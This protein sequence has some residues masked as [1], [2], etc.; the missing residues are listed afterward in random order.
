MNKEILNWSLLDWQRFQELCVYL[1]QEEYRNLRFEEYLTQGHKQD[2]IDLISTTKAEQY[3]AIQCKRENKLIIGQLNEIQKEF[4]EGRFAEKTSLFILATTADLQVP[5]LQKHLS[6]QKKAFADLGVEFVV[7][8]KTYLTTQLRRFYTLVATY[9]GNGVAEEHCFA[10]VSQE[11]F[12]SLGAAYI[13]R[14]IYSLEAQHGDPYWRWRLKKEDT[15]TVTDILR[16]DRL[17]PK[18]ICVIGDPYQGKTYML[19]ETAYE[20]TRLNM[21]F[22]PIWIAM[23]SYAVQPIED[24]LQI[25]IGAWKSTPATDIVVFLDGLDEVATDRFTEAIQQ[26]NAFI[27]RYPFVTIIFSCR[28]LF[29]HH[30]RLKVALPQFDTYELY[31][32][33]ERDVTEYLKTSLATR[34]DKFIK[35]VDRLDLRSMLYDPFYLS[36]FIQA[37][38]NPP[39]KVPGSRLEAVDGFI[40]KSIEQSELRKL[41]AGVNFHE[42]AH[43]YK[44]CIQK[45]AFALQAMGLNALSEQT[46]QQLF[47][48]D[49]WEL[50]K[51]SALVTETNGQWSFTSALFQESLAARVL[52]AL[53]PQEV[54]PLVTVG[55]DIRKIKQKW[56]QTYTTL[57]GYTSAG[58]QEER[59]YLKVMDEDSVELVFLQTERSK[60]TEEFRYAALKRLITKCATKNIRPIV[61][62]EDTI[63]A[64]VGA[65][66][67]SIDLLISS[68]KNAKNNVVTKITCCR[69]LA[70]CTPNAD[71]LRRLKNVLVQEF[72]V[73]T[74]AMYA[75]HCI[76]LLDGCEYYNSAFIEKATRRDD[77]STYYPY[78]KVLFRLIEHANET[79]RFYH[80]GI[81]GFSHLIAYNKGVRHSYSETSLVSFLTSA[82]K[83]QNL[84]ALY[85]LCGSN[86]WETYFEH[87]SHAKQYF[88][89]RLC[90][91]T[92]EVFKH[93]PEIILTVIEYIRALNLRSMG[94]EFPEFDAFFERTKTHMMVVEAFHK[95]MLG[96]HGWQYGC[97]L[98]ED[99]LDY[100]LFEFEEGDYPTSALIR[101]LISLQR[102]PSKKAVYDKLDVIVKTLK[103]LESPSSD[104]IHW[105]EYH[106]FEAGKRRNDIAYMQS[107]EAFTDGL[108]RMFDANGKKPIEEDDLYVEFDDR[109]S[110]RKSAAS[111]LLYSYL[112]QFIKN[113]QVA[114]KDCLKW[115]EH[116]DAFPY[117]IV[118]ELIHRDFS[119]TDEEPI[120]RGI[121]Q[122]YY[123]KGIASAN[124]ENAYWPKGK[125]SYS[126]RRKEVLLGE[127]FE[128]YSFPTP[129][130]SLMKFVWLDTCGVRTLFHQLGNTKA[131]IA[132]TV[133]NRLPE[134]ERPLFR[135]E[136]LA[137]MRMDILH[138]SVFGTH[139]SLCVYLNI[140][141][142]VPIILEKI[143]A[144]SRAKDKWGLTK[145][146]DAYVKLNGDLSVLKPF[147]KAEPSS[148][149]Y[150]FFSLADHLK[151]AFPSL[152][153]KRLSQLMALSELAQSDKTQAALK[154]TEMGNKQGFSYIIDRIQEL[155]VSPTDSPERYSIVK[156]DTD[157]ALQTIAKV[158]NLMLKQSDGSRFW[159]EARR[160]LLEWLAQLAG[161]SEGDLKKVISFYEQAGLDFAAHPNASDFTYYA[162]RCKEKFKETGEYI[163]DIALVRALFERAVPKLT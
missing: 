153:E 42:K 2:G 33:G 31:D 151:A 30:Y 157:Y 38:N 70:H 87:D 152:V 118:S 104:E 20:L 49:Q 3:T 82:K 156:Q 90:E 43:S 12:V 127:I 138:E 81:E 125:D 106:E 141:E 116:P 94:E 147:L 86:K 69:I 163:T 124:F 44:I 39:Y 25:K 76:E 14:R 53:G 78:R 120:V 63:G 60:Y 114:L 74:D 149:Y 146:I 129:T 135:E 29:Y 112:I 143:I 140:E 77:L 40:K 105:R 37:Y 85:K 65:D 97:L 59:I 45:F 160:T 41:S 148:D 103:A 64:F 122:D 115:L 75:E 144:R 107:L 68:L 161:K 11:T 162:E 131:S 24:L 67:K 36:Q 47:A 61:V 72:S 73:T 71:A 27:T 113:K 159:E 51:H 154:L 54:I 111:N 145:Y 123:L 9:F 137:N 136:V 15:L 132:E 95:E 109:S 4:I 6:L 80:Y 100:F 98:S 91:Q 89:K 108:R 134:I 92:A 142:A 55:K 17:K 7:W 16:S 28:K 35:E 18:K 133:Y 50:L 56:L 66:I 84:K 139:V 52:L 158:R 130:A 1:A 126:F 57:L 32:L 83:P 155:G 102:K 58:S 93:Y 96:E 110:I 119:G 99:T 88:M 46:M 101:V 19:R 128:K 117:F 34:Y 5:K 79:D 48:P 22:T 62:Y 23:K 8:D 121:I 21:G 150:H 10:R 26:I 13:P